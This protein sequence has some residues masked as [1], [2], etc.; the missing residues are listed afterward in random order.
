[1]V[2]FFTYKRIKQTDVHGKREVLFFIFTKTLLFLPQLPDG[3]SIRV[4]NERFR[5]PEVLFNPGMLGMDIVGIHESIYN[6]IKK[7]DVD[8]RKDLLE[9]ILLSGNDCS[10]GSVSRF[11]SREV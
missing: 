4:A 5:C 9:N 3:Q 8:I 1:M 7:C 10:R 2:D 11:L 6:C